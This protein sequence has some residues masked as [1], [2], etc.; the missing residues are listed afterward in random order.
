MGRRQGIDALNIDKYLLGRGWKEELGV[1]SS[2]VIFAIIQAWLR[3]ILAPS[4]TGES[5]NLRSD[6]IVE[7]EPFLAA[8]SR[9]I[10]IMQRISSTLATEAAYGGGTLEEDTQPVADQNTEQVA[11]S[12][13]LG[14]RGSNCKKG[15]FAWPGVVGDSLRISPR[16]P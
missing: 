12:E 2:A 5:L 9:A 4:C 13:E 14:P 1:A 3:V 10:K 11:T 7:I 6:L 15:A 16:E 8:T